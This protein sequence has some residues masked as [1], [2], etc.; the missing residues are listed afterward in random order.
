MLLVVG[1]NN[2]PQKLPS[3]TISRSLLGSVTSTYK[4]RQSREYPGGLCSPPLYLSLAWQLNTNLMDRKTNFKFMEIM[5]FYVNLIY[6][7]E[8]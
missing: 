2:H 7:S 4:G 1:L 8:I 3:V 6:I 5:V